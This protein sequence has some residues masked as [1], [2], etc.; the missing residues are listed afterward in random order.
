[1][2]ST[3]LK[4]IIG[5]VVFLGLGYLGFLLDSMI[6]NAI[7][8]AVPQSHVEWSGIIS[9]VCWIVVVLFTYSPIIGFSLFIAGLVTQALLSNKNL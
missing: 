5:I 2:N 7:V 3:T 8:D 4:V 9:I 6:V 1:M